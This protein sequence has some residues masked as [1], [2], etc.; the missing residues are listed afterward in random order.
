[1]PAVPDALITNDANIATP[2]RKQL[3]ASRAVLSAMIAV[4]APLQ[5]H[6]DPYEFAFSGTSAQSIRFDANTISTILEGVPT[7]IRGVGDTSA[8]VQT[9]SGGTT[10]RTLMLNELTFAGFPLADRVLQYTVTAQG[11]SS[12]CMAG[13]CVSLGN[14]M[15]ASWWNAPG[16]LDLAVYR[17]NVTQTTRLLGLQPNSHAS[18]TGSSFD[19]GTAG[20]T[21]DYG[22]LLQS[23]TAPFGPTPLRVLIAPVP[24]PATIALVGTGLL[25]LS[26]V[27]RRR[28]AAAR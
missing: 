24:E 7:T 8:A 16:P 22:W 3:H 2:G 6:A 21:I 26:V 10:V 14:A 5:A 20:G 17:G 4:L 1:M 28:K 18:L 15:P 23:F 9:V 11:A 25:A 27:A 13:T 12:L 19:I